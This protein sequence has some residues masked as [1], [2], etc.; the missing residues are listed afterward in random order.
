MRQIKK[1]YKR[2]ILR[3][4]LVKICRLLGYELINQA[5]MSFV[6]SENKENASII[7]N[8]SITLPLGE[9]TIKRKIQSNRI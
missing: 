9:T 8:K 1:T 4:L 2:G 5:D 6:T 7:G 3:K